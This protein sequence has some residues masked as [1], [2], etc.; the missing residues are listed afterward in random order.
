MRL[1][2]EKNADEICGRNGVVYIGRFGNTSCIFKG[3][4]QWI[5]G[6]AKWFIYDEVQNA[7]KEKQ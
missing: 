7:D 1:E 2:A 6:G 4:G 3:N 5:G